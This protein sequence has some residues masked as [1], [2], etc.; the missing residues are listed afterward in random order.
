LKKGIFEIPFGE[1]WFKGQSIKSGIV[2]LRQYQPA[3]KRLIE[4]GR[5]KPSFIFDRELRIEDAAEAY[6][7][8]SDHDFIKSVIR[9]DGGE[10]GSL[11]DNEKV[12]EKSSAQK[13]RT[14]NGAHA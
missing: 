5:A 10:N 3:L 7:E 14:R 6:K 8:F 9:L 13:K 2:Q 12:E 11:I 1:S 4:S